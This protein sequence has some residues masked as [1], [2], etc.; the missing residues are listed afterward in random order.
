[1]ADPQSQ[2]TRPTER[3]PIAGWNSGW[4]AHGLIEAIGE[5]CIVLNEDNLI[6]HANAGALSLL[7]TNLQELVARRLNEILPPDISAAV[8]RAFAPHASADARGEINYCFEWENETQLLTFVPIPGSEL[9]YVLMTEAGDISTARK[10]IAELG[11]ELRELKST[12]K[13]SNELLHNNNSE[14][15]RSLAKMQALNSELNEA[16]RAQSE[17]LANT[18][19]ELRTPLNAVM[20]FLQMAIEGMFDDEEERDGYLHSALHS[21][22]HLLTLINEVL[23]LAKIEAGQTKLNIADANVPGLFDDIKEMFQMKA[24][25]DGLDLEFSVD[26]A[27]RGIVRADIGRLKQVLINLVGNAI[28]F[29]HEGGI[30]VTLQPY[31][32]EVETMLFSIE[33]TGIGIGEADHEKVFEKFVQADGSSTRKYE[34]TGL[35]LTICKNYI[36]LMGGDIWI[37]KSAIGRG[38]TV[39]FTLP[40]GG[41]EEVEQTEDPS[42]HESSPGEDLLPQTF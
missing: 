41:L 35:G 1:M 13:L 10:K 3:D 22:D 23:D 24:A 2:T 39:S 31:P 17:F 16:T 29:T 30:T 4:D 14:I 12:V 7:H 11:A 9:R 38:T 34:G 21:A 25:K 37:L 8:E 5:G 18:S 20:G 28:K 15:N 40:V 19:H 42:A 27:T 36:T 26:P 32:G 6:V 33:D